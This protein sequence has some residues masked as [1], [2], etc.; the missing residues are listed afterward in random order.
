MKKLKTYLMMSLLIFSSVANS[1]EV[2]AIE[3]DQKAPFSGV[4]MDNEKSNQIKNQLLER[5]YFEKANKSLN[6]QLE[7]YVKITKEQQDLL[8]NSNSELTK[9]IY[10]SLGVLATGL[11]LYA[12][13]RV[14]D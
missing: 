9:T 5:D 4:L 11:T 2:V 6:N 1:L 13:K 10:F 7:I 3:K 8:N 12:A 14:I